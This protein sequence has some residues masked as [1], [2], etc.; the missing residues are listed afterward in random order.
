MSIG[1][2]DVIQVKKPPSFDLDT[3]KGNLLIYQLPED[4]FNH[5]N[6]D[7]KLSITIK[8]NDGERITE[9]PNWIEYND[10]LK[11]IKGVVPNNEISSIKLRA[12]AR[13]ERGN[14]THTDI[15]IS[16]N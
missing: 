14:E 13:D 2:N 10:D 15:S 11:Q 4:T 8:L 1:K 7:A 12:I 6:P 16:L 9:L 3:N 5:S